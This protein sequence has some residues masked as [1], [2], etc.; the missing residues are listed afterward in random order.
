M[1]RS[2]AR[3][4]ASA[5]LVLFLGACSL[6]RVAYDNGA[7]IL[8][9]MVDDYFDLNSGQRH[10]VQ[11]RFE[12]AIAW[13][14]AEELPEYRR[15]LESVLQRSRDG[16]SADDARWATGHVRAHYERLVE[17]L[18]PDIADFLSRL[19]RGQVEALEKRFAEDNA[20]IARERSSGD[21]ASDARRRSERVIDQVERWTGRLAP[22]Q[23][24]FV[25]TRVAEMEDLTAFRLE[26]RR[27]RQSELI[28]ILRAHPAREGAV[29]K[30]RRL[31]LEQETWRVPAYTEK[32]KAREER[33]FDL[34]ADLD[35]TLSPEQRAHFERRVLGYMG[36]ITALAAKAVP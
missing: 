28:A 25:A 34:L 29:P 10:W 13:H 15:F 4:A 19:D 2:F 21:S 11:E 16:I 12:R 9:W 35:V 14:R 18:L 24:D 6:T 27:R 31:L 22:S 3:L 8:A 1:T 36:D 17:R 20:K 5:L 30:L 23:R 33:F 26:D 7:P 32:L